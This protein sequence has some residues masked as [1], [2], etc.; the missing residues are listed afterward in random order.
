MDS[1]RSVGILRFP[2]ARR[3]LSALSKTPRG[4]R[5]GIYAALVL[6]LL[7]GAT[8]CMQGQSFSDGFNRPDGAVGN[9]WSTWGN[10]QY[11]PDP[12]VWTGLVGGKLQTRGAGGS[13]GGIY[14]DFPV[15]LPVTFSFDLSSPSTGAPCSPSTGNTVGWLLA[16]NAATPS[17]TPPPYAN[18]QIVML[19]YAGSL[20][21]QRYYGT[22]VFS[23]G[24]SSGTVP[25]QRD[26]GT[27]S[28]HITGQLNAD[29]SA[30]VTIQYTDNQSP[31][32]VTLT[33]PAATGSLPA[34]PGGTLVF[35]NPS[36]DANSYYYY[37]NLE[38]SLATVPTPFVDIL[39]PTAAAPGST[40]S[41]LTISGANF[42][43]GSTVNFNGGSL[44][45]ATVTSSQIVVNSVP[46]LP[47]S[48][49]T[50]PLTVINPTSS[51][52]VG[53]SNV[54]FF[55]VAV[56]ATSVTT[57]LTSFAL[58]RPFAVAMG[59]F[60]GDGNLDL[61][62]TR[63]NDGLVDIFLG[64]ATGTFPTTPSFEFTVGANP[65]GIAVGDFNGDG[66]LD[67][68][69][70]CRGSNAA[71]IYLGDGAGNFATTAAS[72]NPVGNQPESVVVG[73]FNGDGKL[74]VAVTHF[75][76]DA[77]DVLLGNGDGTLQTAV[78]Y[79]LPTGSKS[80]FLTTGDFNNDGR[81]DLAVTD[82]GVGKLSILLGNGDGTFQPR[83]DYNTGT[84]PLGVVAGDFNGDG[85][86][87][88]AV[89][90]G[91]SNTVSVFLGDGAGN[92]TLTS[93]PSTGATPLAIAAGDFNNDGNLDLVV[94]NSGSATLSILLGDGAGNF[95]L[96]SSPSTSGV[97]NGVIAVGDFNRDGKLDFAAASFTGNT[98]NVL[99]Q[100]VPDLTITKTHT[101]TFVQG[102]V[103]DTYTI[104]VTNS[105]SA[106][107]SGTVTVND[108]VPA[109]LT[110]TSIA[111]TGW[112]CTQPS[113]PCTR[114]DV[115]A[116]NTSYPLTLTVNVNSNAPASI[117]NTATVS[118]GGEA[119]PGNNTASDTATV[120]VPPTI[121]KVFGNHPSIPLNG[122]TSLTF[123]I[124]NPNSGASLTGVGFTDNLPSPG[125]MVTGGATNNGC[126]GTAS[127]PDTST[128]SLS[129]G[130]L[131]ASGSCTIVVTVRGTTAGLQTNSVTVTSAIGNG[132][133]STDSITVV[134]PPVISKAFS[135]S[136]IPLG[137][138]STLSFTL[139]NP[140]SSASLSGIF[141]GDL[142]PSGLVVATPNG[143]AGSCS[144]GTINA[145]AGSNLIQLTGNGGTLSAASS[146]TFSVNVTATSAGTYPNITNPPTS[147]EGGAGVGSTA[148]LT[149]VTPACDS[150]NP[151]NMVSWWPAD[152]NAND[153][154]G[155]N[156]G[157]LQ[158]GVTFGTGEVGQAFSLNGTNGYVEAADNA[159]LNFG[160]G[161]FTVDLWVNF[162]NLAG[163][164]VL[165]EKW[166]TSPTLQGWTLTKLDPA[167][168]RGGN[169]VFLA[170]PGG[171][172][173]L[174]SGL[175]DTQAAIQSNLWNHYA[176]TRQSGTF[177]LYLNG[178]AVDSAAL[179]TD[180]NAPGITLKIGSRLG[181]SAFLN[182]LVDEVEVF[183]RALSQTE[184][185]GIYQ[186]GSA[187]KCKAS[188]TFSKAFNP[189]S[190]PGDGTGVSTLSFTIT[191]PNTEVNL[192]G[193]QFNDNLPTGVTVAIP[194]NTTDTCGG[195]LTVGGATV[196]LSGGTVTHGG[197]CS[198][199]VDVTSST[200]GTVT[201]T[202]GSI[203][204]AE[205]GTGGTASA[206][207][208]VIAPPSMG[209]IFNPNPIAVN[210][211][212]SLTFTITN[213]T[214]N[215]VALAGVAFTDPLPGGLTV[216]NGTAAACNGGT[217]TTT[218]P[219]T[220]T[221]AG[222]SIPANSQCQFSVT[223]TGTASGSYTNTTG[224][225]TS[226]NGGTGSAATAFLT[227][228][229]PPSITK[230]FT[231]HSIPL[232]GTTS[233]TFTIQNPNASF[234]VT[235]V[236]FS[237]GLPTGLVVAAV[238]G[239]TNNNCGGTA[240][241]PNSSTVSLSG[242]ALPGGASCSIVVNVTGA[243]AGVKS[244][245]VTVTSDAGTGNTSTD[246]ITVVGPPSIAKVFNPSTIALN[247]T[248]SLNFT[249]TNPA[250]NPVALAGV[251]FTDNLPSGVTVATSSPAS[252]CGGTL[253]TTAPSS[254]VLSG[255]TVVVGTPCTFSVPVTGT[256]SGPHTN[257]T[258]NVT[259]TTPPPTG[260]TGNTA[261]ATL[262]VGTPPSISKAFGATSIPLNSNTTLTF[263]I[264]N[265]PAN[266]SSLTGVAFTDTLPAGLV[267]A[268]PNKLTGSC[269]GGTITATAG[270]GA[271][272]LSGA[273]LAAN[274]SC[275]FSV[276]VTGTTAGVKNNSVTVTSNQ[277][278]SSSPGT[279]SIT[280]VAPPTI[281]K[282]FGA[283]SILV[284][285]STSLSFTI[286]NPN[287]TMSLTGT[288]FSDSLPSGL[289]IS[290]PNGLTGTCVGGTI[291]ATKNTS[292]ISLSGATLAAGAS[293]TFSV[294]VTGTS[295]GK[296]NNTTGAI[297]AN[298]CQ[299]GGTASASIN[300]L[301]VPPIS[302]SFGAS[303]IQL[304]GSTTLSFTISNPSAN[305]V[306]LTGIG[307]TD[308]LPSGLVVSTP[309]GLSGSCDS[310]TITAT[311]GSG[312]IM[313]AGASLNAGS[314][315]TFSAKVTGTTAG[316]KNNTTLPI[317]STQTG[318]SGT[319]S[320]TLNVVTSA[321]DLTITKT[322]SGNFTQGQ[323]G[324]QYTI[325][326]KNVGNQSTSGTVKVTDTLPSGLTATSISG[327]GWSCTAPSGPCTRSD[328]L[329]AGSSYPAITL[330]VNVASNAPSSV[331]NSA[332]VSGGGESNTANDTVT[333]P[334]NIN[335]V[336][337]V[338]FD[339]PSCPSSSVGTYGGINWPSPWGC[340][341]AG[342]ANDSTRT[343]TWTQNITS[344]TFTF[345]KPSV[346]TSLRAGGGST[347]SIT[348]STDQ[349]E[350]V[351]LTISQ[352]KT[353]TLYQT[354][355]TKPATTVTVK[356]PGGWTI[357]LDD[358]TYSTAP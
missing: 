12:A 266:S 255:A 289:V 8:I 116:A 70:V 279:A 41:S 146:C 141:F 34:A 65:R 302:K 176:L 300:V 30:K 203:S 281:S 353:M 315:C 310:G 119:N 194:V 77:V 156:D 93:S 210:G 23:A 73:D 321:P 301:A 166:S 356:Y 186:A 44:T 54:A 11:N 2:L 338:N 124:T 89:A 212:T 28:A 4:D 343:M 205:A 39:Q 357:E 354:G 257:T 95:S 61:A 38:V 282:V 187:G 101:G 320:A 113:G 319:A 180:L 87:D 348:I 56:A 251:G 297:T 72:V 45:P 125:L 179:V 17:G 273:T 245:S 86:L 29:L 112:S 109:G 123:T 219:T 258:G 318:P 197:S 215:S 276:K 286:T 260:T 247:A 130:T 24:D 135:P 283:A 100:T 19:Q 269:G 208:T 114:S 304:N 74:D 32:A 294:N 168:T 268:T 311:A 142:L 1:R 84:T 59:D 230:A 36:C 7:L 341:T 243:M 120:V 250:G 102:N 227:V 143:L 139:T 182:G 246:T 256:V 83:V 151:P 126:G 163:E 169:T 330:K 216:A 157:T 253:T 272:S 334:T 33:I 88:L 131:A 223:V 303:S 214:A 241:T 340:E 259:S 317:T 196:S 64:T 92:F 224:K 50:L 336:T 127:T 148:T 299:N 239:L 278:G 220:I 62:V 226:T 204:T 154:V 265:P 128:V 296:K 235:G 3:A 280:V 324:A 48:A 68:V 167:D 237:D 26:Y 327:T 153:V 6:T 107:T 270:S 351:S 345:V 97:A 201:N 35:G 355:F 118:G 171:N 206:P 149:I 144:P 90:N 291:T 285:G 14:R 308:N 122:T 75:N 242:G 13:A 309:N 76:T 290:S 238:S 191:N 213:P 164:Q 306:A 43:S 344:K 110:A 27:A 329:S 211:T 69:V 66:K 161:D 183:S 82:S 267:V 145:S 349:G 293:C 117:T 261:T 60:N 313:L 51:P 189:N 232:G 195:T 178:V 165:I 136:T 236:G 55:P 352:T 181:G 240:S 347:G 263:T 298:E 121:S 275:T 287:T 140:N 105:G 333:D 174:G 252:V 177:T 228:G 99:L 10:G 322:H 137:N 20:D 217:L 307:F 199:S 358:L 192:T 103:G 81:L 104:T 111:G 254:I 25:G 225:V 332:T 184:I 52:Q 47:A 9:G 305:P 323:T 115:L 22:P 57:S 18:S 190:I 221:L 132:N 249:I 94:G 264:T 5:Q 63:F 91:G 152:G 346:L 185:Q 85:R 159:N 209:K 277:S 188:P 40:L 21:V 170:T 172:R 138:V 218:A 133:T 233:L 271:V 134:A 248:T 350:S 80:R 162:S 284:G 15:T 342:Y 175:L 222:G 312:S 328:T 314:S 200:P 150:P 288:S 49:V 335:A 78:P 325:T 198:V 234:A 42:V 316:T 71:E 193:V 58:N 96:T 37:D 231:S 295:A 158:G 292:T 244:N 173:Y 262:T 16:F 53:I 207:L 79:P 147:N 31:A 106:P 337:T 108:N 155:G 229:A 339:S 67:L 98:V 326:V 331:T 129:G 160:T 46:A 202:T 274:A